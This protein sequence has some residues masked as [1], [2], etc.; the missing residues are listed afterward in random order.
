MSRIS[1]SGTTAGHFQE[2]QLDGLSENPGVLLSP[3]HS[4]LQFD[5]HPVT[6]LRNLVSRFLSFRLKRSSF[7]SR[8]YSK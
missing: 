6:F 1:Q 5:H 4:I 2:P 3:L 8:P 7:S